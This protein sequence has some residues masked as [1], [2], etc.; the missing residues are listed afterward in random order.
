MFDQFLEKCRGRL[1]V[2]S[3]CRIIQRERCRLRCCGGVITGASLSPVRLDSFNHPGNFCP[4]QCK[5]TGVSTEN[6]LEEDGQ[7]LM[8]MSRKVHG[9]G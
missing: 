7:E 6:E 9:Q 2:D 3:E 4:D 1:A 8:T 5:R